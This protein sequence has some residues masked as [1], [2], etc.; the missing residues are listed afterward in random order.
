MSGF[1]RDELGW[2]GLII[3]DALNMH[4]VAKDFPDNGG[5][6]EAAFAA[7]NDVLCFADKPIEGIQRILNTSPKERIEA[8]FQRLWQL[9]LKAFTALQEATEQPG[10]EHH[11]LM[12]KLAQN[13]ITMLKGDTNDLQRF[14]EQQFRYV[15]M[16]KQESFFLDPMNHQNEFSDAV[17]L[18]I[19]PRQVKPKNSFGF[20]DE[21]IHQMRKLLRNEKVV[22]YLFG[23]PFVLNLI[24][25]DI[26][27]AVVIVYQDTETFQ[28]NALAHF[29]GEVR[30]EGQLPVT[31]KGQYE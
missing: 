13:S 22:L 18:G 6:E 20:T 19:F 28:K 27:Q 21:E 12:L 8:S 23:N 5:I 25:W 31:L 1:L 26:A 29:K 9:K 3:S 11:N 10:Q 15:Q 30:A 2:E 17:V 7:G 16:G 4:A 14:R 24:P